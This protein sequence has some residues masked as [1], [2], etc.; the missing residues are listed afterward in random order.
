MEQTNE[1]GTVKEIYRAPDL[2]E[3]EGYQNTD[4]NKYCRFD[5]PLTFIIK[6][7]YERDIIRDSLKDSRNDYSKLYNY[8]SLSTET[9]FGDRQVTLYENEED[10]YRAYDSDIYIG[11]PGSKQTG[12][13]PHRVYIG[14]VKMKYIIKATYKSETIFIDISDE[15]LL[16][17]IKQK[18]Q[19]RYDTINRE[20]SQ[21][22]IRP[23]QSRFQEL[24]EEFFEIQIGRIDVSL[25][26]IAIVFVYLLGIP[27]FVGFVIAIFVELLINLFP[28]SLTEK[29]TI[30]SYQESLP[31]TAKEK[32]KI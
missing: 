2:I 23:V 32:T 26:L 6:D 25:F 29:Y 18:S 15:T 17:K 16:Q 19:I 8:I 30:T 5:I 3:V 21:L 14:K 27:I 31:E 20:H 4:L 11:I 9:P 12:T 22:T 13:G 28:L 10:Y 24:I 1:I 7:T